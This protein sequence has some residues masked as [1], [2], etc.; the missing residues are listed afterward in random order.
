MNRKPKRKVL[1][2]AFKQVQRLPQWPE[3]KLA[4][5]ASGAQERYDS[6]PQLPRLPS[7]TTTSAGLQ[8]LAE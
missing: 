1:N 6:K 4:S 2:V 7:T 3:L 5:I 8:S